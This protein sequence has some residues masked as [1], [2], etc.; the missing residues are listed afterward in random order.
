LYG[1]DNTN[2]E[3]VQINT[4]NAAVTTIGS[5][6]LT[7]IT[8]VDTLARTPLGELYGIGRDGTNYSFMKFDTSTGAGT[9]LANLGAFSGSADGFEYIDSLN[10]LV[11]WKSPSNNF[12]GRELYTVSTT[13]I[14]A[15]TGILTPSTI[16]DN[17]FGVYDSAR[18][19]Y[20]SID[21]N[22]GVLRQVDL[23]T[24]AITN[25]ASMNGHYGDGAYSA[26]LDR[27]FH[28]GDSGTNLY[29]INVATPGVSGALVGAFG[30]GRSITA[31]ATAPSAAPEPGSLALLALGGVALIARR[32]KLS[33]VS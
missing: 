16:D 26:S 22:H 6:G 2:K 8:R 27:I 33:H 17:D 12:Y 31:I 1:Y 19:K 5:S 11:L 9:I 25:H 18:N 28:T 10:S 7:T 4:S 32:R 3:L 14:L 30:G 24:G 21:D 23:T 29:S 20:Y 15:S 13:G